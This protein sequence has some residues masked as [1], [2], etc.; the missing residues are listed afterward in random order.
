CW[1]QVYE[2]VD[3]RIG[4]Y[5]VE[6]ENA[7]TLLA[8]HDIPLV[9]LKNSGIA[10]ALYPHYGACPM[11]DLDVLVRKADFRRAHRILMERGYI[12]KFRSPLERENLDKAEQGGGA[13]YAVTLPNGDSLWF[14]LQWRPVAGRWIRPDQEPAS[15]ELVLRSKQIQGSD[16]RILSPEDNLL[17]VALHTAKHT[18]V[19]APG[20]RLHT[21]VDRIVRTENINWDLFETRVCTLQVKTAV[22][23]SLAFA[24]DLLGTPI[25]LDLLNRIRPFAWKQRLM[26]RWLKRVGLF[27]PE[28]KKWGQLGYIVFVALIYDDIAGLLKGVF[29]SVTSINNYYSNENKL[30]TPFLYIRRI[31]GLIMQHTLVK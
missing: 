1:Q 19:R 28:D 27:D 26:V 10:K 9:A 31:I 4:Q 29:P 2:E 21:D 14:E 3:A 25:P 5:M 7:A 8:S 13:E 6:L 30:L 20:F 18:F 11:G 12:L 23:F 15:D 24:H 16:V 17:Q 22:F